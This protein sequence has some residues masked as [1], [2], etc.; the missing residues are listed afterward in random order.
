MAGTLAIALLGALVLVRPGA[1]Q[2][3]PIDPAPVVLSVALTPATPA[4]WPHRVPATGFVEP[5]Q[6]ASIGAEADTL[7]LT[8]VHVN[9]GDTVRR[10]QLLA[11]FS[12]DT[13]KADLAQARAAT[14]QAEAEW[15][16]ARDNAARAET[17]AGSGAMA[18]QQVG[19]YRMASRTAQA[20]L[21]AALAAM[22]RQAL[23]LAH[24]RVVAPSDGVITARTATLG[25]AIAPGQELFRLIREG[26]LEWR[27][28][29][30]ASDLPFLA[31]GQSAQ[32]RD[33]AGQALTGRVRMLGPVIDTQT[34]SGTV[35]V[36]LP[37]SH[38]L[39]AGAFMRGHVEIGQT[40]ALTLPQSAVLLRD[41][42]S[43]VMRLDADSRVVTQKVTVGRRMGDRVEIVEGL[44]P[45]EA[46]VASGLGFLG[47]GDLVRVV[48]GS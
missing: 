10:G 22:E 11:T 27:A 14:A 37:A 19:Q 36:D 17:L 28:R 47:D 29:V 21:D 39:R 15:Y 34:Y 2:V 46:V 43:L 3:H 31:E 8:A 42:H 16:E 5:W 38:G 44:A 9:V 33:D 23:R 13:V 41:G 40:S 24:T 32:L 1:G 20:R 18:G 12:T 4:L 35:Y 30:A 26:R 6:E 7:R 25:A 48:E 45:S